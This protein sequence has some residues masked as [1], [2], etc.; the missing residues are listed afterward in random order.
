MIGPHPS[1]TDLDQDGLKFRIDYRRVYAT[2]L[3]DW[4]GHDAQ[5]V[6]GEGFEPLKVLG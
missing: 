4:L 6:L 2:L 1:L 3:G 5:R